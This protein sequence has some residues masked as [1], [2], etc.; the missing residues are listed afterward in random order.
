MKKIKTLTIILAIALVTMV[1]FFGVYVQVQNR[2]EDKT[3]PYS[4]A[5]DIEGTR[6]VR[7]VLNDEKDTIIK[8]AEGKEVEETEEL[9]DEQIQEKGYTKEEVPINSDDVKKPENYKKS[10]E[11]IEKRLKEQGINNYI[12]KLD[13]K[14]G[15]IIV[16]LEENKQTD[17]IVGNINT[18][19]KFEITDSETEEVLMDNNDLK[20]VKVMYGTRKCY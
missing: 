1:S 8:D 11:I 18:V 14:T 5:M 3:K 16:E 13:E 9:T 19:G 12:I 7:L 15:D 2:M 17:I 10:K 6:N 20:D 4:Y